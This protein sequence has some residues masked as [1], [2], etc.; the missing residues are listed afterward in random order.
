MNNVEIIKKSREL[1]KDKDISVWEDF[2]DYHEA[3][4][5][6]LDNGFIKYKDIKI[7]KAYFELFGDNQA[8]ESELKKSL[9]DIKSSNEDI[10]LTAAKGL[11]KTVRAE[12][13]MNLKLWLKDPRTIDILSTVIDTEKNEKILEN[14]ILCL[15]NL[16]TRYEYKDLDVFKKITS[17]FEEASTRLKIIIAQS[18]IKYPTDEKWVYIFTVLCSKSKKD[19]MTRLLPS[20]IR[21]SK[22]LKL[23]TE[24]LDKI[25]SNL[26][27]TVFTNK[28]SQIQTKY[29]RTIMSLSSSSDVENLNKI[30]NTI[31]LKPS[32][33]EDLKIKVTDLGNE[34]E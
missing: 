13:N 21:Y 6:L 8:L 4:D 32:I 23:N 22:E 31:D 26:Y 19:I 20:I 7:Q 10:R 33:L 34:S 15:G 16:A 5:L 18:C 28:N 25:K 14:I 3:R 17:K 2:K 11:E 9:N 27:D 12:V 30:I 29:I 1:L 24:W